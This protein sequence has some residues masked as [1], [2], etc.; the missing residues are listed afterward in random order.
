M[1]PWGISAIVLWEI[2]K[3]AQLKRSSVNLQ[4]QTVLR[5]LSAVCAA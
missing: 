3:L 1:Q 5:V 4:D 2:V